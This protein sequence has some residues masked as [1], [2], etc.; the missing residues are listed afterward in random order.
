LFDFKQSSQKSYCC[1]S[2]ENVSLFDNQIILAKD[3]LNEQLKKEFNGRETFSREDLFDFFKRT[4]P[5]LKEITFRWR[6]YALK[7]KKIIS[8]IS[9]ELFS[10]TYKPIFKP[11]IDTAEKRISLK[12]A[13]QFPSLKQ[14]IWSTKI[15]N[16]FMLHQPGKFITIL[17]VE[18]DAVEPVFHFLKD[19]NMRDVYL[20]PKEKELEWYVY[21]S[22][23]ALVLES[24][25]SKAPI[26]KIEDTTTATI[27][28]IIVDIFTDKKLFNTFQGS[29][30]AN[31]INTAYSRYHIDFTK[32][33]SYGKRRRKETDLIAYLSQFT[34]I[35][36]TILYD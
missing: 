27:E 36:K 24:L 19:I 14:C 7:E 23:S 28:K 8:P 32:L 1:L 29:E 31:I 22:N 18:K 34:D 10:F 26:Q 15:L 6:I 9:R 4:E 5:D 11:E 21:E 2:F 16:E 12:I 17:E 35:P 25:V 30:L 20:L 33:F 13:K 3:I